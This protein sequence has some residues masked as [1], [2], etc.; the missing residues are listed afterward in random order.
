MAD[1]ENIV[2]KIKKV[3]ALANGTNSKE[4]AE[5][6][7]MRA[8]ELLLS[9]GLTME[10][11][12]AH[13][14]FTQTDSEAD[15]V[16]DVSGGNRGNKG[17][18]T[19]YKIIAQVVCKNFRVV[20]YTVQEDWGGD[21]VIRMVGRKEDVDVCALVLE[22]T[23][24]YFEVAWNST[25]KTLTGTRSEKTAMKGD[26]LMGFRDGLAMKFKANVEEKGLMVIVP[27]TVVEYINKN[28]RLSTG[29]RPSFQRSGDK[30]VF[31][32]GF[33]DGTKAH[34]HAYLSE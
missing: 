1:I 22:F 34:M 20:P 31:D 3:L 7:M 27:N 26:Y 18:P 30:E 10:E 14:K 15:K 11:V 8:Q 17:L 2:E 29:A 12:K 33:A 13:E 16:V 19:Y 4:E 6:A 5:T 32:R 28:L 9:H 23:V 21:T 25:V 24:H